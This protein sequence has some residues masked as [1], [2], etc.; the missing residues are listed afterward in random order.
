MLKNAIFLLALAYTITL[1]TVCLINLKDLPDTGISF[2][3]KIFHFLAYGLFTILW[4]LAFV[5]SLNFKKIK[6][7]FYAFIFAVLFGVIIE[8]LQHTMTASRALDVYDALANTLGA[9]IASVLIWFKNS[10]RV[11]NI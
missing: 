2:A 7:L 11:K 6:A 1:A 3:D 4:Y 9:L 10:L 8:I 5:Y